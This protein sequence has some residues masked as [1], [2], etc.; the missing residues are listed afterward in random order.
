MHWQPTYSKGE[1]KKRKVIPV[2]D[3]DRITSIA[4]H[5]VKDSQARGLPRERWE[6]D[7]NQVKV[8]TEP[9]VALARGNLGEGLLSIDEEL[10]ASIEDHQ[11]IT[12]LID[13]L[14]PEHKLQGLSEQLTLIEALDERR[15]LDEVIR[16]DEEQHA[17]HH[18]RVKPALRFF[19]T[20]ARWLEALGLMLF[21]AYFL[22]APIYA[23]WE[24]LGG[25]LLAL[26]IVT[27]LMLGQYFA[28]KV[29][30]EAWNS[31]REAVW[32]HDNAERERATRT[33]AVA[34][35][36]SA[37]IAVVVAVGLVLRVLE[38]IGDAGAWITIFVTA[39]AIAVAL[40]LPLIGTVAIGSDGSS[41][42]RRRDDLAAAL[43]HD[44]DAHRAAHHRCEA[45]L[46]ADGIRLRTLVQQTLPGL[47][48]EVS[49]QVHDAA[50][51]VHHC[52]IQ[53]GGLE[54]PPM[55]TVRHELVQP[56]RSRLRSLSPGIP[57]ADEVD[58]EPMWD[59]VASLSTQEAGARHLRE[60]LDSAPPHPMDTP[61][62]S[63]EGR[64]PAPTLR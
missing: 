50:R 1:N 49:E 39:T 9:S 3:F 45:L 14:D 7:A 26:L 63:A 16:R 43:Q 20:H 17:T 53:I 25:F 46:M 5:V 47:F 33:F 24:D 8:L 51:A 30:G 52:R 6:P 11:R 59:R 58:L 55:T 40:L 21:V 62:E 48:R 19:G 60:R 64:P 23:P 10:T 61:A 18:A 35:A 15:R 12:Q 54:A 29:A 32:N 56:D 36:L 38:T 57:G 41:L 34:T 31:R 2:R 37:G 44:H 28:N 42:S 27:V 13:S 4:H 22:D